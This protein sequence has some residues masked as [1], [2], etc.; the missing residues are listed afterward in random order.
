MPFLSLIKGNLLKW[1]AMLIGVF[2]V[3]SATYLRG[4]AN[5][6]NRQRVKEAK[7]FDRKKT[8]IQ[9]VKKQNENKSEKEKR[10]DLQ[11]RLA[12]LREY[13]S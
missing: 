11:D 13:K 6:K 8:E 5:A 10:K 12:R 7:S 9:K 4:Q 2:A 3:L 1:G